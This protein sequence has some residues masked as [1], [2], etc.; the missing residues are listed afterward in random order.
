MTTNH[1]S[2]YPRPQLVRDSFFTLDGYWF[3]NG[4][5]IRIPFPPQSEAS[6]YRGEVPER[7]VYEKQFFL[8]PE[9]CKGRVLLHFGAVDQTAEVRLNDYFLGTHEGGYLPFSFDITEAIRSRPS[10]AHHSLRVEAE[11]TL[12]PEYPYGKQRKRRGGM[13][14]TPVSGIWQSVWMESV[15]ENHIRE[16]KITPDLTGVTLSLDTS[17]QCRGFTASVLL[18]NGQRIT[19]S[20]S[21]NEGR[22]ELKGAAL[23]DD[24]LY[25]PRLWTPEDPWLYSLEL[26]MGE[27]FVRSYFALRTV[28]IR[29]IQGIRRVLLNGS[30]LF[31]HGVLDQGYFHDGIY[32][33]ADPG[34]Y[35]RDIL[36]MKELGFNLLRKHIKV[37]PEVFYHA[38]DRLGMLVMQDMVNSGTYSY[39]FD[40]VLPTLG[41]QKRRERRRPR[42]EKRYAFFKEHTKAT[43][44]HLYNHPSII[45]YTI[46]NEGWGQFDSDHLYDVIK[47]LDPSRL[48]DSTSGWFAQTKNDFDSRHI[49]F[50]VIPLSVGSRPLFVSECG[51]Y[52]LKIPGHTYSPGGSYGYG[53]CRSSK[54]LTKTILHMYEHMI[55]PFIKDGVCGCIYTQLSDVEDEINGLYTYDRQVCKVLPEPMREMAQRL[56]DAICKITE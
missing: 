17:S 39:L 36:R 22:I 50:K 29:E 46:F 49:Y 20:F 38:C 25:S 33:P 18:G 6:G 40:T 3:L 16:L 32:L 8:P 34:E 5:K 37:E 4:S 41:F 9:F 30:P 51:G 43:V 24:T 21:G 45:A 19:H 1:N 23:A 10:D 11:D 47:T 56:Y 14:Y 55:L 26:T 28:E 48:V 35:E 15:P 13:W 2:V 44:K 53:T 52:S 7:L 42:E 27:D 54:E 12:S 31:I